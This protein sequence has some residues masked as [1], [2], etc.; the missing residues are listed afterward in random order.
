MEAAL[1][2][3]GSVFWAFCLAILQSSLFYVSPYILH[4]YDR[5]IYLVHILLLSQRL[6]R[7][8]LCRAR[9]GRAFEPTD[10]R[11]QERTKS[12]SSRA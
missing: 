4:L 1:V 9:R 2:G 10:R 5:T 11:P 8:D 3:L 12:T 6:E 7:E